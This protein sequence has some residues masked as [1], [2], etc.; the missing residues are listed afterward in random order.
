[1]KK[2]SLLAVLVLFIT[3]LTQ[4]QEQMVN[5]PERNSFTLEVGFTP[6]SQDNVISMGMGLKGRYAL[7]ERWYLRVNLP[8]NGNTSNQKNE[9]EMAT[10]E[11]VS[12]SIKRS[13]ISYGIFPGIEYHLGNMP[14]LSPYFGAE[15]GFRHNIFSGRNTNVDAS[16]SVIDGLEIAYKKHNENGR[17]NI[18]FAINILAGVDWY[19]TKNLYLGAEFGLG[20]SLASSL[21]AQTTVKQGNNT[22]IAHHENKNIFTRFGFAPVSLIRLGWAF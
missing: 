3:S 18:A 6:F 17:S 10:G 9:V 15:I 13:S 16:G 5:K 8:F 2:I 21:K 11:M 4:A 20:F 14:K 22:N 19:M 1:M 7:T 12:T